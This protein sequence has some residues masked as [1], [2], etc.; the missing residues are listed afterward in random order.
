[1]PFDI[2]TRLWHSFTDR[3]IKP[4]CKEKRYNTF[5]SNLCFSYGAGDG[6]RTRITSLEGWGSAIELHLLKWSGLQDSN[7][8]PSGPKPDALPSW[9]KSRY[10]LLNY[11][12]TP[13]RIRTPNPLIRSQVFYP[14]ELRAHLKWRSQ[15][16]SNP[17]SPVWQTDMLTNYTIGPRKYG[18]GDRTWT[19]TRKN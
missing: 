3:K 2:P 18:A 5:V 13:E 15:R 1:M 11:N 8:W 4:L 6:N 19:C 7:L 10:F 14:I 16:D 17:R 12:G 9:A